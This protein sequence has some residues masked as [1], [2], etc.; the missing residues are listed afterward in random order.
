M[1]T[2]RAANRRRRRDAYNLSWDAS[3]LTSNRPTY[4]SAASRAVDEDDEPRTP[5]SHAFELESLGHVVTGTS[6]ILNRSLEEE[7]VVF[8]GEESSQGSAE[9]IRRQALFDADEDE[10]E[11][12]GPP[13][14]E[15]PEDDER[16]HRQRVVDEE[17]REVAL[18][19]GR[20]LG[21]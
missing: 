1:P 3:L 5:T 2:N 20:R 17:M 7:E 8:Q 12:S 4:S 18:E 6:G 19:D 21:A 13:A 16:E 15:D 9:A 14:G 10:P 11:D